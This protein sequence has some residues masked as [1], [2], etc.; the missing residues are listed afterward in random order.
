MQIYTN[1]DKKDKTIV[2]NV[3]YIVPS[4]EIAKDSKVSLWLFTL[5]NRAPIAIR[6]TNYL[7]SDDVKEN[8]KVLK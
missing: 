1:Y 7:I 3:A 8:G 4:E 5:T 6:I 2:G